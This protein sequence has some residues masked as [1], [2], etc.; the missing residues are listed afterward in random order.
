MSAP[1]FESK[2]LG[3]FL[4]GREVAAEIEQAAQSWR[5][6]YELK[7]SVTDEYARVVLLKALKPKREE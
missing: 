1:Y 7:P 3:L 6:D 5:F 2:T 4:K